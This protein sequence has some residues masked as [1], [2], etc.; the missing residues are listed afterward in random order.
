M[1]NKSK[2]NNGINETKASSEDLS[3]GRCPI[4]EQGGPGRRQTT[5]DRRTTRRK[6]SPEENR[7]VRQCYYRSEYGRNGYKK[8][9]QVIWNET[10]MFNVHVIFFKKPAYEKLEAGAP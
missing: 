3:P 5:A 4:G 10:G 8:R 2:P 9:M 7:V 1:S 6:W